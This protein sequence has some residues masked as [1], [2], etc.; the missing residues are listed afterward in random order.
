MVDQHLEKDQAEEN[1]VRKMLGI[2]D[3][4][5]I[6]ELLKFIFDGD[7]KKSIECTR[8]MIDEGL[9][10]SNLKNDILELIYFILQKKI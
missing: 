8:Q 3:R 1:D 9:D 7:Q 6:L 2:A 4:S 5:K 10:A